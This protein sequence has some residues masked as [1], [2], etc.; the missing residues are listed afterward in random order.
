MQI[1]LSEYIYMIILRCVVHK[2]CVAKNVIPPG[3]SIEN[4]RYNDFN[5]VCTVSQYQPD[6]VTHID[7]NFFFPPYFIYR[8]LKKCFTLF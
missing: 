7:L 4:L 3:L 1:F 8:N 5:P 6:Y 2:L